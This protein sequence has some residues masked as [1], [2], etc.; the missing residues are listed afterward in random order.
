MGEEKKTKLS[1]LQDPLE[2]IDGLDSQLAFYNK[3]QQVSIDQYNLLCI[4]IEDFR[5]INELYGREIGRKMLRLTAKKL[6][7]CCQKDEFLGR[8]KSDQFL[9]LLHKERASREQILVHF[10]EITENSAPY[11][12]FLHA[13]VYDGLREDAS[14]SS[15]CKYASKALA[16]A[17]TQNGNRI[18]YYNA[19]L[20]SLIHSKKQ[21]LREVEEALDQEDFCIFLQPRISSD[22]TMIG[23][24]TLVR[25]N[26][27]QK[28]LLL[29]AAFVGV[30][31][32]AGLIYLIDRYVWELAASQLETWYN[33]G[34]DG[35]FLSV[36]LSQK[37]FF[38][39]DIDSTFSDLVAEYNLPPAALRLEI[40]ED[41]FVTSSNRRVIDRLIAQGFIVEIDS[42]GT[43]SSS[44]T[45]LK[46][47]E[48]D[49]VK[50]APAFLHE[51]AHL[52]R[53]RIILDSI[54]EMCKNLK[55]HI[56]VEGV[57]TKE[58]LDYL[59]DKGCDAFQGY[60]FDKPLPV[61][62]FEAKYMSPEDE[63]E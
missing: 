40:T 52:E 39:L 11:H 17:E 58:Q 24:E 30:L 57:E 63:D 55:I 42:F 3:I 38:Y 54:I 16:Y 33:R 7:A 18:V 31:E 10:N 28:G 20:K 22:G 44:L 34:W 12:I 29:P 45:T 53:S 47:V 51:T 50:I 60:Y 19:D 46:D 14:V 15:M 6:A 27:P 25:W 49:T 9:L 43:G 48:V 8:F 36:N 41:V 61:T 62:D 59:E 23:A 4:A 37:D 2:Q 35:L 26:H 5:R 21:V 13:G 1:S 32:E 56:I